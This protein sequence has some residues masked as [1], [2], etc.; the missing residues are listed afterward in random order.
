MIDQIK[1]V[2]DWGGRQG[3]GAELLQEGLHHDDPA[4][5]GWIR[6]P[7]G[8]V[9]GKFLSG[10]YLLNIIH[11]YIFLEVGSSL[12]NGSYEMRERF[13]ISSSAEEA[14]EDKIGKNT[15]C[16]RKI[17]ALLGYKSITKQKF[18]WD[19]LVI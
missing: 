14:V 18:F 7:R 16:P 17:F 13:A 1:K 8:P 9:W 2:V 3:D 12:K 4:H 15:G 6:H 11:S 19:T 10:N 5:G